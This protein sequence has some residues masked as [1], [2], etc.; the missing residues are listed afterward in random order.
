MNR[1]HHAALLTALLFL[2]RPALAEASCPP[3]ELTYDEHEQISQKKADTNQDCRHD[4]IVHYD[5]G[6][7]ARAE[8]DTDFDGRMDV[9]LYFE[10]ALPDGVVGLENRV[11]FEIAPTQVNTALVR[12]RGKTRT[13]IFHA[14]APVHALR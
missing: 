2:A 5:A 11:F 7:A 14:D 4:E 10:V 12:E 13:L 6:R 9:W 3:I 8:R 1:V